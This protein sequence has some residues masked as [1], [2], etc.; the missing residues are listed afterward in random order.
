MTGHVA[1][2]EEMKYIQDRF[3]LT[4]KDIKKDVKM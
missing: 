3:K 1:S 4:Q 2:K